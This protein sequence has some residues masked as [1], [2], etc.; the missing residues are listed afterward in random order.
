VPTEKG[1]VIAPGSE[2]AT[3]WYSPSYSQKTGLFYVSTWDGYASTFFRVPVKY[4]EG[5]VYAGGWPQSQVPDTRTAENVRNYEEGYGAVRAIDPLTGQRRWEFK[6]ND[7][8][9]AGVLS[10]ASNLVFSGGREGYF[11]ALDARSGELLWKATLG[12]IVASGPIT[13]LVDGRQYIA[14]AAGHSLFAFALKK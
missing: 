6:M 10:T 8:T 14:V 13:Y 3:N 2:G 12:G 11:F 9:D 1:T 4:T 7:V 5:R